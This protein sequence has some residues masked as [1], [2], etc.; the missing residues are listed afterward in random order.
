MS[1][2][3]FLNPATGK[4]TAGVD[5]NG[6]G[7]TLDKVLIYN[8][9]VTR[10]QRPGL[11][12]SI[13][14]NIGD[15]QI[16]AGVWGERAHHRQTGPMELIDA[17]GNPVD[18]WMRDGN[19][20]R[21]DGTPYES[22]DWLT[23]STAWQAFVQDTISLADDKL[24]INVGVRAPHVKRDFTNYANEGFASGINYRFVKDYSDILPQL[25]A[26]YRITND[27]QLFTS[28][29]KNFKAP[30]NFVYA[31]TGNNVTINSSGQ[32]VLSSDVKPE[33]SWDLDIG[34][35]HQSKAITTSATV[36]FTDFKNRQA[37]AIDPSTLTSTLTNVGNV[38]NKGLELELG[39]TPVN[40][41]SF[42]SSLGY[43]K[44]EIESN[45][46]G[47]IDSATKALVYLP[48]QGKVYP[49]SPKWKA[50]LSGSYETDSWYVRLKAKY[51]GEQQA[52]LVNDELVPKYTLVD[53]D[54]GYQFPTWGAFKNPKLTLNVSNLLNKEYRNPTGQATNATQFGSGTAIIK[55]ANVFYYLGSPRFVS[56]TLRVD[57]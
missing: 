55:A 23:I 39:N 50:G 28:L 36:F 41:W 22:R 12:T 35:R 8:G 27:D 26:R 14:E 9:S 34:Y 13:I 43:L 56:A 52:T 2:S 24:L 53:L 40:G 4:L 25:G 57:F 29:A 7:D 32:A 46:A 42:Y 33:T 49:L 31:T 51:T 18:A 5:L 6:D 54:A 47:A 3:G 44:T 30:P 16:L 11:T 21:P 48:T 20:L 45:L 17:G 38:K 10:T 1:E 19:I 37:T 15:H